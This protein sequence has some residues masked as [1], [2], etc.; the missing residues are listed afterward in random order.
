MKNDNP[1]ERPTC[2]HIIA[3]NYRWSI[4]HRHISYYGLDDKDL[5]KEYRDNFFRNYFQEK[6]LSFNCFDKRFKILENIVE[7]ANGSVFKVQNESDSRVYT[8]KIIQIGMKMKTKF[9]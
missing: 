1:D 9:S 8:I 3:D 6:I 5:S 7:A 4:T 2:G